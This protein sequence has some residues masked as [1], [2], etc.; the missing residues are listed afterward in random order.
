MP[1]RVEMWRPPRPVAK[2]RRSEGRENSYRR[3][4]CDRR[5]FAWRKAVLVRDN[6]TCVDCQRICADKRQAHAD[7]IIPVKDRPDLRYVVSN[8]ACRCAGCHTRKTMAER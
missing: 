1:T 6:Y 8:G 3:G 7:H 2:I 5:H 4:Y